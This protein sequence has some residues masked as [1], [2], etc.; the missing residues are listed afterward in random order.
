LL[1]IVFT[2]AFLTKDSPLIKACFLALFAVFFFYPDAVFAQTT[3]GADTFGALLCNAF[4]N[5]RPLGNAF[6][7]VAYCGA[8]VA[9]MYGIHYLRKH[10]EGGGQVHLGVPLLFLFGAACLFALPG[11][12]SVIVNSFYTAGNA[13]LENCTPGGVSGGGRG[14]DHMMEKFIENIRD[15]IRLVISLVAI[16]AGLFFLISGLMKASKAG[17]DPKT[18]SIQT[19][20]VHLGFG[21]LL[22]TIGTNLDMMLASLFG[23]TEKAYELNWGT[24]EGILGTKADE[25]ERFKKAIHAALQFVQIVG[26]IA[27]VRG[28]L[29]LKKVMD[30]S[31]G[32][33]SLTQ[34]LTHILGGCLAVNIG[35]FLE[36]MD[37]TFGSNLI[38]Q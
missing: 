5:S 30:A 18:N 10:S 38:Q 4:E 25:M 9:M 34:G 17:Q 14:L 28:W 36:L 7:W 21:A 31:G 23:G 20:L 8:I 24:V 3:Q 11:I 1:N 15:P 37:K 29:I 19:I 16:L 27:F 33:A 35:Q 6:Q 13:G 12:F 26:L 2:K 32:N 22:M